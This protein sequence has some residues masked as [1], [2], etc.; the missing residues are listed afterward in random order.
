MTL[1]IVLLLQNQSKSYQVKK[2]SLSDLLGVGGNPCPP[3]P[4]EISSGKKVPTCLDGA[5]SRVPQAGHVPVMFC[6]WEESGSGYSIN[7][8]AL[9][10]RRR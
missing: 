8:L 4:R 6:W 1:I 7:F 5:V 9:K 10:K 3:T 2:E